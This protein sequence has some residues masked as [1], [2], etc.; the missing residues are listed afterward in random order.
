VLL[1]VFG[2]ALTVSLLCS[3]TPL[4]RVSRKQA[5]DILKSE[6]RSASDGKGKRR[7]GQAFVLSEFVFSLILLIFGALLVTNFIHL[8]YVDPGFDPHNL[9]TF[10]MK[11]PSANE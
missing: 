6:G 4:L 8:E 7:L 1:F 11:I 2:L 5:Y 9:L 10:H 3:L